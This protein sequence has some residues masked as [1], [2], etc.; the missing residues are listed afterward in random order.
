MRLGSSS[1]HDFRWKEVK[2]ALRTGKEVINDFWS[3]FWAQIK[4]K[5]PAHAFA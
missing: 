1:P 4:E 5:V 3:V 2:D